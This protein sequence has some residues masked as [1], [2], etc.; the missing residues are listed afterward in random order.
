ME[1]TMAKFYGMRKN[2]AFFF[3]RWDLGSWFESLPTSQGF[4]GFYGTVMGHSPGCS[5]DIDDLLTDWDYFWMIVKHNAP[6][7]IAICILIFT[8]KILSYISLKSVILFMTI[9]CIML[10][11]LR[12]YCWLLPLN[13]NTCQVLE[14]QVVQ[15]HA[16]NDTNLTQKTTEKV[17]HYLT[18]R[19]MFPFLL[20]TSYHQPGHPAFASQSFKGKS[21]INKYYDS[22]LE[23]DWSVGKIMDT[24]KQ[25]GIE[26]DTIVF[27]LSD[28][29]PVKTHPY[30]GSPVKHSSVMRTLYGE[31]Y[32]LTEG[33]LR[34]PAI[35]SWPNHFPS[36]QE[37][38]VVT[39]LMD[40]FPTLSDLSGTPTKLQKVHMK[41]F[42]GKSLLPLFQNLNRPN[43][44]DYVHKSLLH[45]CEGGYVSAATVGDYKVYFVTHN[46]TND[47]SGNI[48]DIPIVYNIVE[49]P[50]ETTPLVAKQHQDV[51]SK[52]RSTAVRFEMSMEIQAKDIVCQFDQIPLPW[53]M[54]VSN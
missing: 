22:I 28:N 30:T 23:L 52:A 32:S 9:I 50:G 24:L 8:A 29:G 27:F 12:V 38:A 45:Y 31:K 46:I 41:S 6:L 36:N 49:D 53:H 16:Y 34:I 35:V 15:K 18:F 44:S 39:S 1:M 26:N 21:G 14:N 48:L 37:T 47:C 3:G 4:G 51:I 13:S 40:I 2:S 17:I 43:P 11:V 20:M 10:L 7:F 19:R 54:W 5:S 33:G 42:D 25:Q